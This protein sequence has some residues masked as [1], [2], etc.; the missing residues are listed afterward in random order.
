MNTNL[1]CL[2]TDSAGHVY[3]LYAV[4][5]HAGHSA[6]SGHYYAYVKSPTGVWHNMNDSMVSDL[7]RQ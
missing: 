1:L 2:Q 5:V 3:A 4:L 7:A 6:H